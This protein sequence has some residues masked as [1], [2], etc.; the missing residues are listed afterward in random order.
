VR[1]ALVLALFFGL[2]SAAGAT[3]LTAHITVPS[4]S[5][6]AVRGTGFHARERVTVT[7]SA[8]SMRRKVVTATRLGAFRATFRGFSIGHCDVY[9]ARAK[10]NRGSSAVVRVIPECA[11]SGPPE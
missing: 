6:V 1:P 11:P 4:L 5:P 7:V 2:L 3:S 10:G 9:T 8:N